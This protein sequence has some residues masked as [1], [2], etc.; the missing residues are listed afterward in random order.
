MDDNLS[1]VTAG[2]AGTTVMTALLLAADA[3]SPLDLQPFEAVASAVGIRDVALGFLVFVVL[4]TV[5]W[6]FC[7]ITIGQFLPGERDAV[8]GMVFSVVLWTGYV[9]AFSSGVPA[10]DLPA[11]AAFT[12]LVHLAYGLT[13]GGVYA[14]LGDHDMTAAEPIPAA[15]TE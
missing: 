15:P 3:L 2:F 5:A 9:T 14:R 7:F 8:R 6:S 10:P 13:L 4:G 11:Y 1:A 12:L